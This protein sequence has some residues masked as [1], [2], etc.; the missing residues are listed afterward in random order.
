[1]KLVRLLRSMVGSVGESAVQHH[2]KVDVTSPGDT[3]ELLEQA[4][5]GTHCDTGLTFHQDDV[6]FNYITSTLCT[7]N[8][9]GWCY[10]TDYYKLDI[11]LG[12]YIY[13]LF[14]GKHL[15][16]IQLDA[17]NIVYF[18]GHG[19]GGISMNGDSMT[20]GGTSGF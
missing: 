20:A 19:S 12:Q 17:F 11:G 7:A 13:T 8:V 2:R 18:P 16:A 3:V 6:R 15:H 1:M 10:T 4:E 5:A 14:M 9:R